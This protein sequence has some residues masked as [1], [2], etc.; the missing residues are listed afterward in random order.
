[1][2]NA[3]RPCAMSRKNQNEMDAFTL[4]K[5]GVGTNGIGVWLSYI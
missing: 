2:D 4:S 5:G 1:M 3:V